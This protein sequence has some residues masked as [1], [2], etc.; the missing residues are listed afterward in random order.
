M[1]TPGQPKRELPPWLDHFNA[2]DL[3]TFFRC[4]APAW[5][6]C[7][8]MFINPVLREFGQATFFACL[9]LF[10]A[11]PMGIVFVFVLT[12]VTLLLGICLAWAWG[13]ITMKAA[14]AI[15]SEIETEILLKAVEEAAV[16]QAKVSGRSVATEAELLIYGGEMLDPRMTAVYYCLGC[17]FIYFIT[18]LRMYNPKFALTQ[19]LGII[20]TDFFLLYGPLLYTFDGNLA[21]TIAIPSCAGIGL[22]LAASVLLFPQ[23]TSYTVLT[24]ME[25]VLSLINTPINLTTKDLARDAERLDLQALRGLKAKIIMVYKSMGP[26]LAFLPLDFSHGRWSA[27]DIGSLREPLRLATLSSLSL[28]EFHIGRTNGAVKAETLAPLV[29]DIEGSW[30]YEK[31]DGRPKPAG[32]HQIIESVRLWRAVR[33]TD[34]YNLPEETIEVLRQSASEI[35]P[36]CSDA[37]AITGECIHTVNSR[38]WFSSPSEEQIASLVQRAEAAVE[39]LKATRTSFATDTTEK[40]LEIHADLFDDEGNLATPERELNYP[41]QQIVFS[42]VFEEHIISVADSLVG[43]LSR[44]IQLSKGRTKARFWFPTRIRYA[45]AW[46]LGRKVAAPIPGESF[47]VDP[48]VVEEQFKEAQIRLQI[49]RGYK[50]NR[51]GGFATAIFNAYHWF[52]NTEGLYALRIVIVTVAL[53]IPAAI[54]SSAGFY[55]REKGIW[56]LIMAQLTLLPY[57][58]D[59]TFS[60]LTRSIATI[61]GGVFG[62]LAWYIGSGSGPGNPY[63]LAAISA[64]MIAI[65]MWSRVFSNFA[66]MAANIIGAAT[67]LLIVGYSEDDTHIPAP[68]NAGIGYNLFWRRIVLVLVG[69]TGAIIVQVFPRP[70]AASRHISKSLSNAMRSL[71]DHY[72]LLLSCWNRPDRKIGIVAEKITL[73]LDEALVPLTGPITMLKYEFSSSPFDSQSLNQVKTLCHVMN[74]TLGRLLYLSASLPTKMQERIQ[75]IVGILDHTNIGDVMAVLSVVE[76][77]LKTGDPLPEALPTPLAKRCYVYWKS[78]HLEAWLSKDL[79]RNED[80]RKFCVA[81]HLYLKFLVTV[82]ELVLL[83]KGMLGESHIIS[84]ELLLQE[85]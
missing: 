11:P 73:A 19:I 16:A 66:L 30:E 44:V 15:R 78:R 26:T 34:N 18:R 2:R 27:D 84:Q 36:A 63:G 35:L 42:M 33:G 5:V 28:L 54:P 38:R 39:N 25:G 37:I 64:V 74:Y 53:A 20:V 13:A 32:R 17:L 41:M 31:S 59:F 8:L 43:L 62:L 29:E 12:A 72:A 76:Q 1:V 4:W 9:I 85:V 21:K 48:D 3:K 83:A 55:Y 79:I 51:R 52:I 56:G 77:S 69:T 61:V 75:A 82:D 70:P 60:I 40:L 6:A 46:V 7:L 68:G 67:F 10:M 57:M 58:A 22:G 23:S 50:T 49:S 81:I 47:S 80:Y 45:V 65:M 24:A 71:S 14:L